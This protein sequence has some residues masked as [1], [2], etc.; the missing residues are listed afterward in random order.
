MVIYRWGNGKSLSIKRMPKKDHRHAKLKHET[1]RL[2]KKKSILI[3]ST[4]GDKG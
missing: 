4:S 2:A 3:Y 1:I